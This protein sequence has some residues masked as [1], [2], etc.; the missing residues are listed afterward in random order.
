MISRDAVFRTVFTLALFT[1]LIACGDDAMEPEEDMLTLEEAEALFEAIQNIGVTD[2]EDEITSPTVEI[3]TPCSGGGE[4][5]ATVTLLPSGTEEV[6]TISIDATLV[7][8]D[9]VVSARGLTFTLNG[10]PNLRQTGALSISISDDLNVVFDLDFSFFGTLAYG[11]DERSG[12]C[13]V[14]F[15]AVSSVDLAASMQTG[16]ASGTLCGN[17]V[18]VDLNRRIT[19]TPDP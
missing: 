8:R 16:S 10:A 14:S 1:G 13:D 9:C 7:P 19:L 3:T 11:L 4:T 18:D 6:S 5:A 12:S 15:R 17:A 2:L